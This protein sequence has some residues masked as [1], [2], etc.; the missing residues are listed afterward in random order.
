MN[1]QKREKRDTEAA[2]GD[3]LSDAVIT[4]DDSF[5]VRAAVSRLVQ[6]EDDLE[7]LASCPD[8]AS[9]LEAVAAHRPDVVVT[10]F[11]MPPTHTDEG[12]QVATRLRDLA[13]DTGVDVLSQDVRREYAAL[14]LERGGRGATGTGTR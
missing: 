13:P 4:A 7:L 5:L 10:D 11:R 8:P 9:L 6:D 1:Q 12:I 3:A 14:L 2:I